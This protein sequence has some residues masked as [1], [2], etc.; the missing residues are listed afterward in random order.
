MLGTAVQLGNLSL[1]IC[2]LC[3][4][5]G[6]RLHPHLDLLVI[7]RCLI[8]RLRPVAALDLFAMLSFFFGTITS[9]A[10]VVVALPDFL[11][12]FLP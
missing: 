4:R 1:Q 2:D 10:L 8:G 5:L 9:S 11:P 7:L 6:E 12:D 3:V